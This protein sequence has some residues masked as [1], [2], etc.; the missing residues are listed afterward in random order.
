MSAKITGLIVTFNSDALIERCVERSFAAGVD[1]LVIWDNSEDNRTR[2]VVRSLNDSRISVGFDGSNHGFGG[3]VNRAFA[4]SDRSGL[5]V[6]V[7]PDCEPNRDAIESMAKLCRD[8]S[9]GVVAPRMVYPDGRGGIAGGPRPSIL[10]ELLAATHFDEHLPLRFRQW[11]IARFKNPIKAGG[12][13]GETL[14]AGGP[15]QVEWVSAFCAMTSAETFLAV[16]GM[17]EE[18]FL[19]F[20]DV[21]F[22][23][24]VS[25]SGLR[26]FVARDAAVLH[27][28]S[29]STGPANKTKH[30]WT[31]YA[32]Y[33][34][35]RGGFVSVCLAW[36]L[37]RRYG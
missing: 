34:R 6:M 8:K 35:K 36:V 7:N 11:L 15:L 31:G 19:Y 30:Y 22:S 33:L 16:G 5:L 32:T 23:L 21:D 4:M 20:E 24:R 1:R 18:Y 28:E 14:Q 10:K 27:I 17:D 37:R 25:E 2:S 12:S 13:L 3:G 9:V 26:N 29:A